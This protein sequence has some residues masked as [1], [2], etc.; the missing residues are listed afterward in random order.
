MALRDIKV[1]SIKRAR[2]G[3]NKL[4]FKLPRNS[5]GI[6]N[7]RAMTT[8][9]FNEICSLTPWLK[10]ISRTSVKERIFSIK[11]N[12][13]EHPKCPECNKDVNFEFYH[14]KYHMY[15]S[16][17]CSAS[18]SA[19]KDKKKAVVMAAYGVDNVSKMP[20]VQDKKSISLANHYQ[21]RRNNEDKDYSGLVYILHFPQHKAV[22]IGISGSFNVRSTSLKRDFGEYIKIDMRETQT[23][24][25]LEASLHEK[26]AKYRMCLEKGYGRTEFFSEDIL[27]L[28]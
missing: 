27:K 19:V 3:L 2:T 9:M 18:S 5:N 12:F 14:A 13:T 11:H 24:F 26:F 4:S 15:C 1:N 25:A 20:E 23:C 7:S 10:D 17:K 22:K 8:E 28:L 6:M 21:S 16:K